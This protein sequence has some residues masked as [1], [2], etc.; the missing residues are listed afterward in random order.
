MNEVRSCAHCELQKLA[1]P[2]KQGRMKK[3]HPLRRFQVVA[4][5]IVEISARASSGNGKVQVMGDLFSRYVWAVRR[6]NEKAVTV[7]KAIL[8][9]WMLRYGPP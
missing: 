6:K 1:R 2:G 3:W 9:D 4:V 7:A 5:D 8:D